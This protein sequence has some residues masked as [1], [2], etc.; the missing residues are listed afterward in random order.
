M[1]YEIKITRKNKIIPMLINIRFLVLFVSRYPK[2]KNIAVIIFKKITPFEKGHH[3]T[4]AVKKQ[5]ATND[6]SSRKLFAL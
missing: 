3:I 4:C 2:K 5:A 6:I 1:L